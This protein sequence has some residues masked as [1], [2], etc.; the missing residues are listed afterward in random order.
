MRAKV[1]KIERP[2]DLPNWLVLTMEGIDEHLLMSANWNGERELAGLKPLEADDILEFEVS[3]TGT[4]RNEGPYM[5]GVKM[6]E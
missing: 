5:K 1:L 2:F 3:K 6:I 4:Y